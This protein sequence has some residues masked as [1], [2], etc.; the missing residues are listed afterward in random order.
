M[1][2]RGVPFQLRID[3][4]Q[5]RHEPADAVVTKFVQRQPPR[6]QIM[7]RL[8]HAIG[9]A[10]FAALS[11]FYMAFGVFY[12]SVQELLFF[13]AAAVPDHALEAVRPLYFALMKLVGGAAGALGLIGAFVTLTAIRRGEKATAIA[14][15]I[16][17]AGPLIVAAYVAE[18]LAARTGSPT[19]WHI[20]GTLLS[21][22]LIALAGILAGV[23]RSPALRNQ[24]DDAK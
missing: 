17:Y 8:S 7:K 15:F 19:S 4:I 6:G 14:L 5:T 3:Q 18:T 2:C 24:S 12:A 23:R 13:H 22:N 10:L 1:R 16:A 9:I 11:L 21:L 20:M